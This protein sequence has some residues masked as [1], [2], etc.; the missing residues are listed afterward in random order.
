MMVTKEVV[1]AWLKTKSEIAKKIISERGWSEKTADFLADTHGIDRELLQLLVKNGQAELPVFQ[2]A[3][4]A[5]TNEKCGHC[6]ADLANPPQCCQKAMRD[7]GEEA[8]HEA[9]IESNY[10]E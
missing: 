8:V 6:G 10:P 3:L 7:C 2:A 9:I 5:A 1:A 4:L